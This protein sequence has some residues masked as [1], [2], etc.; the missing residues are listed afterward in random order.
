MLLPTP[1]TG[2][3]W[4]QPG[5]VWLRVSKLN[6]IYKQ[7]VLPKI[8]C[9]IKPCLP[10]KWKGP[11][12]AHG[13]L[14]MLSGPKHSFTSRYHWP[15]SDGGLKEVL[16]EGVWESVADPASVFLGAQGSSCQ[17]CRVWKGAL[18]EGP[19]PVGGTAAAVTSRRL[20]QCSSVQHS[21]WCGSWH[22]IWG[23]RC[24]AIISPQAFC[25]LNSQNFSWCWTKNTLFPWGCSPSLRFIYPTAAMAKHSEESTTWSLGACSGW[26]LQPENILHFSNLDLRHTLYTWW[27]NRALRNEAKWIYMKLKIS[28]IWYCITADLCAK[29]YFWDNPFFLPIL[30]L[31]WKISCPV[32][33]YGIF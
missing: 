26:T 24:M 21:H 19:A 25:T 10:E 33:A 8:V 18:R 16:L 32:Q 30:F 9:L 22:H 7:K 5:L 28:F 20:Q 4:G 2:R 15:A 12:G 1:Q 23:D 29:M 17:G 11:G 14:L 3:A 31:L 27:K 13:V 6:W